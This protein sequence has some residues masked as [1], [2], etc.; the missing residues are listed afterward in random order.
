[1]GPPRSGNNSGE[2]NDSW[3]VPLT[4]GGRATGQSVNVGFLFGIVRA[5]T[6]RFAVDIELLP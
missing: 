4:N 1:M 6:Y 3:T 2:Q 5:D